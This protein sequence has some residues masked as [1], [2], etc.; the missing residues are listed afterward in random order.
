CA[1]P[2]ST[3]TVTLSD[4]ESFTRQRSN[5]TTVSEGNNSNSTQLSMTASYSGVLTKEATYMRSL[6]DYESRV[7]A[8][9]D[10]AMNTIGTAISAYFN[11]L[12]LRDRLVAQR[13]NLANAEMILGYARAE[14]DAGLTVPINFLQQQ[15]Q[16][17]NQRNS[18]RALEQQ[19]RQARASLALLVG[20]NVIE[21]YD[22]Q[23]ETLDDIIVP[24]VQ[25]GIP[26][27]LLW[28]RPDLYQAELS[29]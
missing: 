6:N 22:I 3:P 15:I 24:T 25:P 26:S 9:Y 12:L 10:Q 21:G 2:I 8:S 29:L 17:E 20:R 13:Q 28:R 14:L 11:L 16:V 1:L 19:E 27:E 5:G 7:A 18:L 4:S 23:G